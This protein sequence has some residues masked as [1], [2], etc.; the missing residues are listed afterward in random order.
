M[1]DDGSIQSARKIEFAAYELLTAVKLETL[2]RVE[3]T[4]TLKD[5]FSFESVAAI[6]GYHQIRG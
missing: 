5:P 4:Q 2:S 6:L 3:S 1:Q